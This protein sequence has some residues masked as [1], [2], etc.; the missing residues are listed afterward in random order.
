[1]NFSFFNSLEKAKEKERRENSI[2]SK[3]LFGKSY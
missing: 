1:M 2:F 3:E